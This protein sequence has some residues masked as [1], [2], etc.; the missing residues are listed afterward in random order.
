ML[1]P[2]SERHLNTMVFNDIN[3]RLTILFF[4]V[5]PPFQSPS[6]RGNAAV[7]DGLSVSSVAISYTDDRP[8]SGRQLFTAEAMT[9]DM[10]HLQQ[11]LLPLHLLLH[12]QKVRKKAK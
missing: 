5:N 8:V 9:T 10:D 7:V 6:S 1:L 12:D 4:S 3:N 11:P 2:K